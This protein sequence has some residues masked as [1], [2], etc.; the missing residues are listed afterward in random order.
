MKIC[1]NPGH[2]LNSAGSG[3]IGIKVESTENRK[4]ANEVI[5]LLRQ[6]GHT[7]IESRV[8]NASSQN[9]YLKKCV[10]PANANNCDLFVSIHF[11]AF[12]GRAFGTEVLVY[13]ETSKAKDEAQRISNK[14]S[15]LGYKNRGVKIR[16]DLYVLRHTKM[17]ALLVECCF[18]DNLGDMNMYNPE[19]MAKAIVEGILNKEIKDKVVEEKPEDEGVVYRVVVGSF[20]EK[21]NADKMLE[22]VKSKGYKDAFIVK[23]QI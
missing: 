23:N 5:K 3:A 1:I 16:N 4:V 13:S 7:V 2:T 20:K 22:E 6:E 18:I 21:E 12:N 8:D 10:E 14:I 15:S 11:N 17:P 19:D 9:E